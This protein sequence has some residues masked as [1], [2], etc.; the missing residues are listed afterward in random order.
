[1]QVPQS[2]WRWKIAFY[3]FLAGTGA[4]A[5]L[6][7]VL[8]DL[9]GFRAP[10]KVGLAIA[11]P[12][13]IVST[14]FLIAD[15]GQPARF[16]RAFVSPGHSWIARGTWILSGFIVLGLVTIALTVWPFDI[17]GPQARLILQAVTSVFALATAIYTGILIGVV[18]GRP[19]WNSP[20]L[21]FLFLI[22]ATS[23]GIGAIFLAG[24]VW[25]S[26]AGQSS[27]PAVHGMLVN[28]GRMDIILIGVEALVLYFYLAIVYGR[29][30]ESVGLLLGGPL[31]G[32]FWVGFAL[33]GLVVPFIL[34]YV[35]IYA[36][37]GVTSLTVGA[38][39]GICLLVGGLF[40]RALILA[41]GLRS[42]LYVRIP[43]VVRPGA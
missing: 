14:F 24:A 10:A 4:G 34:D 40:L 22:S 18:I 30:K 26:M 15:L 16:M 5:Y 33:I 43:V 23:T 17:L 13:V 20:M 7:A 8:E 12:L 19:F 36:T 27:S 32:L 6:A 37:A 28:L 42:P 31:A 11:A 1:M 38:V 41:A 2:I 25:F 3:L 29:S 35:A 21:P 9:M 39:S